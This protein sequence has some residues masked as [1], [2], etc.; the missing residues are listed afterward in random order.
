MGGTGSKV[1]GLNS[2]VEMF[3]NYRE[4]LLS[5]VVIFDGIWKGLV[6]G[7]GAWPISLDLGV[8]IRTVVTVQTWKGA[9][10]GGS[11]DL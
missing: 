11:R 10:G 9:R 1:A 6:V 4:V 7:K 5:Q 8:E 3:E 2:D